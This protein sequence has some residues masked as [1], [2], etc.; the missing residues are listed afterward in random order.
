MRTVYCLVL[1]LFFLCVKAQTTNENL[2]GQLNEMKTSFLNE[3]YLGVVKYTF[4]KVVE[5]MGGEEEML[6]TTQTTMNSMKAQGYVIEDISF[7]N[8]SDIVSQNGFAQC[9]LNQVLLMKTP[10]GN[11]QSTTTL[12]A[13]SNDNG[14]NWKF[15]DASGI[16]KDLVVEIFPELHPDMEIKPSERKN[17]D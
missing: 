15:L 12:L 11:I 3:A 7:S 1:G 10:E 16:P 13:V 2:N 5:M 8:P 6:K 4:P 14:E 17:I 9:T